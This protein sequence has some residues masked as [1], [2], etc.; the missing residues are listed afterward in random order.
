MRFAQSLLCGSSL[1]GMEQSQWFNSLIW[2]SRP[3][4]ISSAI[5][6]M[7]HHRSHMPSF[8]HIF[9]PVLLAVL[10]TGCRSD[11]LPPGDETVFAN[12][13]AVDGTYMGRDIAPVQGIDDAEWFDR[14]GREHAELPD[15]LVRALPLDET[16]VVADIGA[17]TGYFTFRLSEVVPEGRVLAVDIDP[18]MLA[19]I[20]ARME[21]QGATNIEIVE[22]LPNDP[23][24]PEQGVDLAL[25]VDSYHEF[26]H[27]REMLDGI[28]HGLR[29]GG[30]LV[31]VEYRAEDATINVEA[32]HQMTEGQIRLEVEAADFEW[33]E[34]RD[35]LPRQHVVVFRRPVG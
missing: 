5:S 30:Y 32:G 31:I 35:F 24:M 10:I 28:Y 34:T 23:R 29:E 11:T 21:Q 4:I 2:V 18:S 16:D 27:P 15:R 22:S 8:R 7:L 14:P 19:R 25:I 6:P 12:A 13:E 17:G 20:R 1:E 3:R 9:L 26:S 33:V